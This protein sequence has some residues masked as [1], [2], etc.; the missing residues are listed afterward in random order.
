MM[1]DFDT[2]LDHRYNGSIKWAQP[3]GR[4]D[5]IGMGTADMD[6]FCPPCVQE[7]T[8]IVSEQNTLNYRIRPDNY[9]CNTIQWFNSHYGLSCDR[10]WILDIPGALA[11]IRLLVQCFTQPGDAVLLQT[12]YFVPLLRAIE[13][14][15]C[16]MIEN[17][18]VLQDGRYELNLQDFEEKILTYR[19]KV[20]LL[21]SPHN[22][23]GRVFTKDE[24]R[25]MVDI[26]EKNNVLIL[27]DEVHCLITYDGLKHTPI[28]SVSEAA[29]NIAVQVFAP[30]KGF[31][32]MGLAHAMLFIAN[33]QLRAKWESFMK[34]FD[35][36]YAA[37]TYSVAVMTALMSG[38]AD[39]WL[40]E[41]TSYLQENRDHFINEI[42]KRGIPLQVLK[43]EASFLFWID[44]R[45]CGIELELLDSAFLEQAGISL[46]NGLLHGETGRGFVRLNF[47]VTRATINEVL[48][49]LDTMFLR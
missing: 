46:N 26:C 20:F 8:R 42:S 41:L 10:N 2:T 34:S 24:L 5:V 13:G 18:L 40:K 38:E 47:G 25:A 28:L 23:T 19:P 22:P 32:V 6:F 1:Y 15:G 49:R 11:G 33:E 44:C 4:T 48:D 45:K 39:M 12:P 37:N 31:N 29:Q 27:S 21:C 35:F 3:A 30:S 16:R 14:S 9:F 7:A 43:P 17:P 36:Y